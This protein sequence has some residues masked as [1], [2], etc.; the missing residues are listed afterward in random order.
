MKQAVLSNFDLPWIPLT[1]LILFVV[2]FAAYTYWTFKKE[3]KAVYEKASHIPLEDAQK[4]S[5]CEGGK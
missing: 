5:C 4:A 1:G 3:N 2:C